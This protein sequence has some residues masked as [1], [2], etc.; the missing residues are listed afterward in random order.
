MIR[1]LCLSSYILYLSVTMLFAGDPESQATVESVRAI[2]NHWARAFVTGDTAYLQSLLAD[3]YV[4]VNQSGRARPKSEIIALA[5]KVA[6]SPN[7][8]KPIK[9]TSTIVVRGNAA[10]STDIGESDASVDLFYYEGGRWHAWCSQHTLV[11]PSAAG[12][13][14]QSGRPTNAMNKDYEQTNQGNR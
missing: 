6:A 3:D 7:P 4:S 5:M 8:P 12:P 1:A 13:S 9:S 10:I 14:E 11:K 2:E